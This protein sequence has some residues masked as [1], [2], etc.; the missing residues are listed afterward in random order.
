MEKIDYNPQFRHAFT[1]VEHSD[2]NVFITGR[3]GTGK[4]TLL[5]HLRSVTG[6]RMAVLAPTGVA[7]LHVQAQT[8]HSFFGFKPGLAP[9]DARKAARS[10][11]DASLYRHLDVIVIDEISMVRADLLDAIDVFLRTVRKSD[12]AFGAVQMVFIG[13]LYQLPPVLTRQEQPFFEQVYDSPYFFSARV[14]CSGDFKL[15]C[16]ELEKVYRQQDDFFIDLLSAVRSRSINAEQLAQ[17][18]RRVDDDGPAAHP[19][20]ICLTTTNKA[21]TLINA[22][23]LAQLEGQVFSYL[24]T[25]KDDFDTTAAP[26]AT[27]LQLKAGAQVMFSANNSE[28]LW[29]NG[30][31]GHVVDLDEDYVLVRTQE[32]L[33][34]SVEPYT[35]SMH[36]YA[37]D[38]EAHC[39]KRESIGTFTQLP[40]QLAWALT[41]HKSQGK[42]F[43][44]VVVDLGRGTFAHG[45]AYVAL[46]RCRCFEHMVLTRPLKPG[47]LLMDWRVAHFLNGGYAGNPGAGLSMQD[48]IALIEQAIRDGGTLAMTYM[49]PNEEKSARTVQPSFVGTLTFGKT[50]YAGMRAHCL[51]RGEERVFRLDRILS[52]EEQ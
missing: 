29:V 12:E 46:S 24:G 39:L 14:M 45:Q 41:I 25:T 36:R 3:A 8:I 4:S 47:H 30:T 7:A 28:G 43:D 37:Y 32:G 2:A 15:E 38:K 6:K 40:L 11:A 9:E 19:D 44:K 50:S 42:T 49:K 22:G 1:L 35:W 20:A 21:A 13:D 17:I 18:N 31:L 33:L 5:T 16:V 26:V 27:E 10:C 52:L 51:L 23:R 34:V 48:K